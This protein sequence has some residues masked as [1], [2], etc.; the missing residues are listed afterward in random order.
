VTLNRLGS[1]LTLFFAKG[2]L[3][4]FAAVRRSDTAAFRAFFHAMLDRR[5]FLAPAPFEA[6]FLSTAHTEDHVRATARAAGE[7]L[8][9]ALGLG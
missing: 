6:W 1:L 5:I 3:A 8:R 2:P 7:S 9:L 4:D